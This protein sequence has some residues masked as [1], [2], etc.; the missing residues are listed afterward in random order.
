MFD[1]AGVHV[2]IASQVQMDL[3]QNLLLERGERENCY[4]T[5]SQRKKN[6][7]KFCSIQESDLTVGIGKKGGGGALCNES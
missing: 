1:R 7:N 2:F 5:L 3:L 6:N 4:I